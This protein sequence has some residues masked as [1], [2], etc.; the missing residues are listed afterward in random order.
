MLKKA[1]KHLFKKKNHFTSL[2]KSQEITPPLHLHASFT[3]ERTE[4]HPK[5]K[6]PH[7][8]KKLQRDSSGERVCFYLASGQ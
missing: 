1:H 2:L 5:A 6:I 3:Q 4:K 7:C 8:D